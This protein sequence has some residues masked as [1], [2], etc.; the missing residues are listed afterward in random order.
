ME[1]KAAPSFAQDSGPGRELCSQ[2]RVTFSCFILV[3]PLEP[4]LAYFESV[5]LTANSSRDG[6][7][8]ET[9]NGVYFQRMRLV[10]PFPYS[11]YPSAIN[12]NYIAEVV[13]RDAVSG[14]SHGI[15]VRF[16]TTAKL[17][18]PPGSK[19]RPSDVRNAVWQKTRADGRAK[20]PIVSG[21][22]RHRRC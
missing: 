4:V 13:R 21:Q 20:K 7:Y 5:I 18:S 8:F 1:I 15:A 22:E 2:A 3:R 11:P 19:L 14:R 16:R 10:V 12:R 9:D 6:V 17:S